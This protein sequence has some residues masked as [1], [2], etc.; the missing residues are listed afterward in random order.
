MGDYHARFCE[1]FKV[2]LLLST[3]LRGRKTKVGRKLLRFPPTR[4]EVWCT[5]N[6]SMFL[7]NMGK[8]SV[9]HQHLFGKT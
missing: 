5:E 4:L 6:I 2:K 3:R 8:S 7:K 9:K 1:R